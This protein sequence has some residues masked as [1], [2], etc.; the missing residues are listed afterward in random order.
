MLLPV[1]LYQLPLYI[2]AEYLISLMGIFL[3]YW[4]PLQVGDWE[5]LL[6]GFQPLDESEKYDGKGVVCFCF[7]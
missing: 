6:S 2:L 7:K 3:S 5:F 4:F 1:R